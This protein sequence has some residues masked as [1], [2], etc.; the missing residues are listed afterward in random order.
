MAAHRFGASTIAT[1]KSFYA[2]WCLVQFFY[3]PFRG[4]REKPSPLGEDFSK[5]AVL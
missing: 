4:M 3:C 5:L 2:E 1:L